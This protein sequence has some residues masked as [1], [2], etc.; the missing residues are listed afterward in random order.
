MCPHFSKVLGVDFIEFSI[1]KLFNIQQLF[2]QQSKH[3]Q[4]TNAP[5]CTPSHQGLS[6]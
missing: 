2:H 5:Q 4:T 6:K 3:Y 1:T